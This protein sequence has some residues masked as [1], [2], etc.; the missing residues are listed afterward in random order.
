M[1]IAYLLGKASSKLFKVKI[2]IPL[3]LVLSVIPDIDLLFIRFIIHRGPTHSIIVAFLVFIP[4]F[5]LYRKKAIPYFVALA[6]HSL[7][8][9]FIIGGKLMLFWPL[10]ETKYGLHELGSYYIPNNSN[11]NL[12]I[13]LSLFIIALAILIRTKDYHGILPK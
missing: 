5:V 9:D 7:I 3:I 2:N 12:A 13:E 1:A 6:S 8:A 4:F 10:T 11:V